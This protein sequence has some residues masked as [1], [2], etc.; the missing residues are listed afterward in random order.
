MSD[1]VTRTDLTVLHETANAWSF[2]KYY[3]MLTIQFSFLH[4]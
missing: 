4:Q 1:F 3:I 2:K